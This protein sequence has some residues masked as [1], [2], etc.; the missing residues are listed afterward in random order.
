MIKTTKM[1]MKTR[2]EENNNEDC[3]RVFRAGI[4]L[5]KRFIQNHEKFFLNNGNHGKNYP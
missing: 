4:Y 5:N 1:Q 2:M 3:T